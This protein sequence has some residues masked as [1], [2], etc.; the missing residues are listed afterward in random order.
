MYQEKKQ[1][2]ARG[3][4]KPWCR[5]DTCALRKRGGHGR[6]TF[7]SAVLLLERLNLGDRHSLSQRH[8]LE[9]FFVS[10]ERTCFNTLTI[11]ICWLGAADGKGGLSENTVVDPEAVSPLS[12]LQMEI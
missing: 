11:L 4:F 1:E 10:L 8:L 5:S 7:E 2:K 6:E 12:F 9:E 3:G